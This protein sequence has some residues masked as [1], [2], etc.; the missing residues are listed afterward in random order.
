MSPDREARILIVDDQREVARVMRTALELSNRNY[1]VIDVPSGEEALLEMGQTYDL[2]ISDYRLPGMSGVELLERIHKVQSSIKMILMSAHSLAEVKPESRGLELFA[3]L[4]KPID[5]D[6]FVATVNRAVSGTEEP[7]RLVPVTAADDHPLPEF[8]TRIVASKLN[9]LRADL[10][11]V[12]LA[13]IGRT[14]KVLLKEGPVDEVPRFGELAVLLANNFTTTAEISTYL[15][16]DRS[17]AVHYYD[18]NWYDIFAL[19]V[20]VNF[21]VAV[22]YPG[23]SQRHM[24]PILRIGKPG[25][26]EIIDLINEDQVVETGMAG[27]EPAGGSTLPPPTIESVEEWDD[28]FAELDVDEPEPTTDEELQD[29]LMTLMGEEG[30]VEAIDVDLEELDFNLEDSENTDV[31]SF[32][33]DAAASEETKISTEALSLDEAIELGLIPKDANLEED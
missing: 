11:A 1:H 3:I 23:G 4:E 13:F 17:T 33:E 29:A 27:S 14:G 26:R 7:S 9:K 6:A 18:G 10:G 28:V 22:I 2:V 20:G 16:D 19:S 12:G 30:E 32:W 15:G 5:T 8:D 31:D 25:V 21:F 24:G